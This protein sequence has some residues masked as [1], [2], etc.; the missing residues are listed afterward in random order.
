MDD[1]CL[2]LGVRL[3]VGSLHDLDV[4]AHLCPQIS[5]GLGPVVYL[6]QCDHFVLR[7]SRRG[8]AALCPVFTVI[9]REHIRVCVTSVLT[10]IRQPLPTLLVYEKECV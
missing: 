3:L 10:L 6:T 8:C 5:V 7:Q 1:G 2:E 9:G 4:H